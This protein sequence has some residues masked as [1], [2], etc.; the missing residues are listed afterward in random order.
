SVRTSFGSVGFTSA[1]I[2][3]EAVAINS[4][5]KI[6]AEALRANLTRIKSHL[7]TVPDPRKDLRDLEEQLKTIRKEVVQARKKVSV[8]AI[9]VKGPEE[10]WSLGGAGT[11]MEPVA[12]TLPQADSLLA[13]IRSR[14]VRIHETEIGKQIGKDLNSRADPCLIALAE[15]EASMIPAPAEA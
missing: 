11:H 9:E 2:E 3:D 10:E 5:L 8:A 6:R 15:L 13:T 7:Q 4:V 12:P 14:Y 1:R